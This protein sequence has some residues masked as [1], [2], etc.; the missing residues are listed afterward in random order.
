MA[1]RGDQLG[2]SQPAPGSNP[3]D[4]ERTDGEIAPG[5]T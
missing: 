1:D 3:F 4:G 5:V 2:N